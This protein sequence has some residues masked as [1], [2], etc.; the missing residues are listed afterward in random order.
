MIA[1]DEDTPERGNQTFPFAH[2]LL[3]ATLTFFSSLIRSLSTHLRISGELFLNWQ[4]NSSLKGNVYYVDLS[5]SSKRDM[6]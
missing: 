2:F 4:R 6:R 5:T 1:F 3:R